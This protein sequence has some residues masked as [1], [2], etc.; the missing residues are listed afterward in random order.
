MLDLSVLADSA[1]EH[2]RGSFKNPAM[3]LPIA[4]SSVA[5]GF[6]ASGAAGSGL[7]AASHASSVAIGL[8]G[9]LFHAWNLKQHPGGLTAQNLFYAAP[10]GAPGALVLAGALGAAADALGGKGQLGPIDLR[11]GRVLA[12]T[13][14]FGLIGTVAEAGML[15]LRGAYQNRAMYLPV[16]LPP[17]AAASLAR[18]AARGRPSGV[19]TALLGA[20]ATLGL[21][22]V[23]FHSYGIARNMG[24]WRNW[25]QNLLAGPPLPAPPSFTGLAVAGF[26]ALTLMRSRQNG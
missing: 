25:R 21:A 14:A 3:A 10:I 5:I 11:S 7:R 19:S 6:D 13:V 4:A 17:L 12:G 23:L 2:Y 8:T 15:H 26:A 18:D 16:I 24:G 1:M 20:T 22:G 9:F